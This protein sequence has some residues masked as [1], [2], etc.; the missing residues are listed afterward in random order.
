MDMSPVYIHAVLSHLPKPKI[1]FD[2]FHII[3]MYNDKLSDLR[4]RWFHETHDVLQ[5][6]D[7]KGIRWLLLKNP[8]NLDPARD[9]S[10]R[11][12]EALELTQPLATAYYMKEE[13]RQLWN[14]PG[15]GAAKAFLAGWAAR[16]KASD[17]AILVRLVNCLPAKAAYY[18][19]WLYGLNRPASGYKQQ[20]QNPPEAGI[21]VQGQGF[22]QSQNHR[23]A[24]GKVRCSRIS[25]K[26]VR[27][28]SG[29]NS[30][31]DSETELIFAG[32]C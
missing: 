3:K 11:L 8:E 24:R 23:S 26:N 5:K 28:R 19:L 2:R 21:W 16:A 14:Q 27:A 22:L 15:K 7:I 31:F 20:N 13:P 6:P 10:R 32:N 29:D 17:T 30:G 9:E 1:V 25:R 4:R 18:L 12:R